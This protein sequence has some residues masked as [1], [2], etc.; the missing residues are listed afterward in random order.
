[1]RES[2]AKRGLYW[3][4]HKSFDEHLHEYNDRAAKKGLSRGN[5]RNGEFEN[6]ASETNHDREQQAYFNY[7]VESK[8]RELS[9]MPPKELASLLDGYLAV[10]ELIQRKGVSV[11]EVRKL[12]ESLRGKDAAIADIVKRNSRYQDTLARLA[13]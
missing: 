1:M 8:Y 11:D 9:K 12:A 2:H 10:P 5:A 13:A 4:E 6:Y 3:D 7:L